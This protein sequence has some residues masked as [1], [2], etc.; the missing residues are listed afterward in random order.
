MITI[1]SDA[2]ASLLEQMKMGTSSTETLS[3]LQAT[4]YGMRMNL[5]T[6]LTDSERE[7]LF[8]TRGG[9]RKAFVTSRRS[10]LQLR[11]SIAAITHAI[12]KQAGYL[13]KIKSLAR[14]AI[15]ERRAMAKEDA[16]RGRLAIFA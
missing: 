9:W 3:S 7:A 4:M 14:P 11:Q 5:A 15:A 13:K 12:T 1:Q 10:K 8:Q 16:V 2:A 6:F